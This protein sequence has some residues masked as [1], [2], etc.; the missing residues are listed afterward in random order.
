GGKL[1]GQVSINDD[2]V[3]SA[4]E[5]A[6]IDFDVSN[7]APV[8]A[9]RLSD[10]SRVSGWSDASFTLTV[11]GSQSD[12]SHVLAG[13]A[14]DFNKTIT[15]QNNCGDALGT[16]AEGEA[17][18]SGGKVFM[19]ETGMSGD[20]SLSVTSELSVNELTELGTITGLTIADGTFSTSTVLNGVRTTIRGDRDGSTVMTSVIGG[21]MATTPDGDDDDPVLRNID[22]TIEGG[23]FSKMI[24]GGNNIQMSK[25]SKQYFVSGDTQQVTISDGLFSMIVAGGD[26]F[27]KGY[28]ERQGDIEMNISG[29]TFAN[30]VG[31]GLCNA[32]QSPDDGVAYLIGDVSLNVTGGTFKQNSWL[33]GG[34]VSTSKEKSLSALTKIEGNVTITVDT[35]FASEDH[36]ITLSNIVAGSHGRGTITGDTKLV[37]TGNGDS[38]VF[39]NNSW[40]WGSSSSDSADAVTGKVDPDDVSVTG[41]RILSF[42]GF[43]NKLDCGNVNAFT[44]VEILGNSD[45][46]LDSEL[47]KLSGVENWEFEY[48][49]RLSG[50]FVNDFADDTLNLTGFSNLATGE[51]MTLM[52]DTDNAD[53][54]NIFRG[55]E[56]LFEIK[57]DGAACSN[58]FADNAWSISAD[59][60]DYR[61]A[62]ETSGTTTSLVL[63]KLA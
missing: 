39:Q 59:G 15:V 46:I 14:A 12:G 27:V 29:G 18:V 24:A 48:N 37:F 60:S 28:F 4:Y 61:L 3:I 13:N 62:L 2:S 35:S 50:N 40:I 51:S 47:I 43:V 25:R 30:Y 45:V 42:T 23:T 58:A 22:L 41:K 32:A 11:S 36:P 1:T 44:H 21:I 10:L 26:R 56:S 31:A 53:G 7:V 55:F 63:T 16:L 8:G 38:I 9:A 20:L 49:S 5:G 17:L 19:L 33:Y 57:M 54:S 6:I 52:T 34:C